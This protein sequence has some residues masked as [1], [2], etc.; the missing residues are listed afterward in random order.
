MKKKRLYTILIIVFVLLS[1]S[2]LLFLQQQKNNSDRQ[3]LEVKASEWVEKSPKDYS[4]TYK[5]NCGEGWG[6]YYVIAK[7]GIIES[8]TEDENNAAGLLENNY[9]SIGNLFNQIK[10]KYDSDKSEEDGC[11]LQSIEINYNEEY[12]FPERYC[13]KY[14]CPPGVA[15]GGGY[16]YSI[17]DFKETESE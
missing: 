1:I 9:Y 15:D 2:V 17:A 4:Y 13:F 14:D 6:N 12:S 10:D 3:L 11:L 5:F 7:D 16:C 8:V